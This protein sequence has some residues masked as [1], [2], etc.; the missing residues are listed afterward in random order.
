MP[1]DYAHD[2]DSD[3]L[4]ANGDFVVGESTL[5]HQAII[6]KLQPG[7]LRQYPKTGV[8]IDNYLLA[9]GAENLQQEIQKNF[10]ADGMKVRSIDFEVSTDG[11]TIVPIV[12]A[13]YP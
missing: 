2:S 4:I 10:E 7:E 1:Y 3:L 11:L 5:Q 8:G 9:E 12:N 13:F 6:V